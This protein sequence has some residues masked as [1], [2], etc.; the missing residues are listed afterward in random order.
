MAAYN[1]MLDDAVNKELAKIRGE[2]L[3]AITGI[4]DARAKV[5]SA[6]MQKEMEGQGIAEVLNDADRDA[7]YNALHL[8]YANIG[9][10]MQ[11]VGSQQTDKYKDKTL[12]YSFR[13]R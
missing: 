1:A 2:E 11:A 13:K 9:T 3:G 4:Q 10:Q 7:F 8:D 6:N 5:L 12:N